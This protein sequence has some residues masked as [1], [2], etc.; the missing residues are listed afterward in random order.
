MFKYQKVCIVN[1]CE[2]GAVI[3]GYDRDPRDKAGQS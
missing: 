3:E 2:C 1:M